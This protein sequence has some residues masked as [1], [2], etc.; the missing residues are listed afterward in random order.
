MNKSKAINYKDYLDKNGYVVF[1]K[2]LPE[3]F[4]Y[5]LIDILIDIEN[6]WQYNS[7]LDNGENPYVTNIKR[8][9]LQLYMASDNE[10][11]NNLKKNFKDGNKSA[12]KSVE[13]ML[14]RNEIIYNKLSFLKYPIDNI[15]HLLG[16]HKWRVMGITYFIIYPGS[17]EQEIHHDSMFKM[18]RFFISIPLHDTPLE[19][20]P[21]IFYSDQYLKDFR[22]KYVPKS[23]DND[24]HGNIGYL[25]KLHY[26]NQLIFEKARR[27]YNLNLTDITVHRD[28]TFHAGGNNKTNQIRKFLFIICDQLI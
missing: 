28:I 21:T 13:Y 9:A 5:D 25:N 24:R 4:C 26:E 18:N 27:Q 6:N 10:Y 15:L 16:V 20:G 1:R 8:E 7:T 14:K 23:M 2:F 17:K 3:Q 11:S 12:E 19:M 22:K